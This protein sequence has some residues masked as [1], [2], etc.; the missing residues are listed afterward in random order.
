MH[1]E[2]N[3]EKSEIQLAMRYDTLVMINPR[4]F[5]QERSFVKHRNILELLVP[6]RQPSYKW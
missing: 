2:T 5:A 6:E 4:F 1:D 3:R